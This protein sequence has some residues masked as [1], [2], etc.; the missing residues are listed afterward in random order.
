VATA[1]GKKREQIETELQTVRK[2]QKQTAQALAAEQQARTQAEQQH[3]ELQIENGRLQE[4]ISA[5]KRRADELRTQITAL[6]DR[7]ARPGN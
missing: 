3:S 5:E 7:L 6:Q 4:R 2:Q 1:V